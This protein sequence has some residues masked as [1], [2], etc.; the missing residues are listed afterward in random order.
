MKKQLLKLVRIH[1]TKPVLPKKTRLRGF[2][3]RAYNKTK[4]FLHLL[5]A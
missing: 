2:V 5:D 4:N 1:S 3:I